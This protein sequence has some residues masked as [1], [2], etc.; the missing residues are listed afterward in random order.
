MKRQ[1]VGEAGQVVSR[2][3]GR[4]VIV[5]MV[6]ALSLR[7]IGVGSFMTVDEEQWMIR[8]G[9]FYHKL[10]D[11]HD[12][13]GTFTTSHPGATTQWLAGAGI[14]GLE[15]RLGIGVDTSNL[16]YFRLVSTVPMAA[17][18][19]AMVGLVTYLVIRLMGYVVGWW[20]GLLLATE[21]Y[22]VGMSQ[23]VHVDMLLALL[24]LAAVLCW[25]VFREEGRWRW[26]VA[27]GVMSGLAL[28]TK[29]LP[30]LWLMIWGGVLVNAQ[31]GWPGVKFWSNNR[32]KFKQELMAGSRELLFFTGVTA[33]VFYLAW[34]ALWVKTNLDNYYKR[35]VVSVATQEHV[36]WSEGEEPLEPLSFYGRTILGRTSPLVLFVSVGMV[37]GLARYLV[38]ERWWRHVAGRLGRHDGAKRADS[39][40]TAEVMGWLL[41]YAIGYVVLISLLAKKADR[42]ALPALVVMPVLAGSG[43]SLVGEIMKK[44]PLGKIIILKRGMMGV[45][46]V[47]LVLQ[48]VG[49]IPYSIA[50]NNALFEVRPPSQQGWGEGLDAAGRWLNNH[51]LGDKLTVASWYPGVT[52]TYFKGKTMSLSSR[53][54]DRVGY[55]ITYRNMRGRG[56]DDWATYVLA[57]FK[58]KVPEKIISIAGQ[59]YAWIYNV[60]GLK[61]FANNVGE[62]YGE[63]EVGQTVIAPANWRSIQLGLANFSGRLNTQEVV[64]HIREE[65]GLGREVRTVTV[66]ASQIADREWHRF[67]FAPLGNGGGEEYYVALTS[68]SST[69]GN[70]ITVL[71]S[72]VDL[73]PGRMIWRRSALPEGKSN[74]EYSRDNFDVAYRMVE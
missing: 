54:D 16:A 61:Y 7:L 4:V 38:Q 41:V 3:T 59:E 11:R 50:Y 31:P 72:D 13:G 66:P 71:F 27:A 49:W 47:A 74:S 22:L 21:P 28:G 24:M 64:L 56:A 70:A 23:V 60:I 20:T 12:P 68:P 37:A 34:P 5:I 18:A 6:L 45:V 65:A 46:T 62:L 33:L 63:M 26:L 17:A 10:F 52:R 48:L 43:L 14:Y 36:A 42:Y 32:Q 58:D 69:P 30:A 53:D 44:I 51:P 67:D 9:E 35:D 55:V 1:Q 57:E 73:L 8:S 25:L 29:L 39:Y 40:V 15:R 2:K 19:A